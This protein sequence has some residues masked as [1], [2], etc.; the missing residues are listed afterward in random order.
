[1]TQGKGD[2]IILIKNYTE[3]TI[4]LINEPIL[5]IDLKLEID[6]T[7]A[8]DAFAGGFLSGLIEGKSYRDSAIL[9]NIFASGAIRLKGFQ[10]PLIE[11]EKIQREYKIQYKLKEDNEKKEKEME[12]KGDL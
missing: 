8:G 4:E 3:D 12:N 10:V 7:G 9:G 1:M 6:Y 2:T 5:I 11:D